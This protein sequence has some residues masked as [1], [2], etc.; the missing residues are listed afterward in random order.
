MNQKE[1]SIFV[2]LSEYFGNKSV[3][4]LTLTDLQSLLSKR[5]VQEKLY[6]H[7]VVTSLLGNILLHFPDVSVIKMEELLNDLLTVSN[8]GNTI[9]IAFNKDT[10][11]KV[12]YY[13]LEND[14]LIYTKQSF[15]KNSCT[16]ETKYYNNRGVK[17]CEYSDLYKLSA[18]PS[19]RTSYY[20][21]K[22]D[23]EGY[24]LEE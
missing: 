18:P 7:P 10:S 17:L 14:C 1:P 6:T 13:K 2:N 20:E 8:K 21:Q 22:I 11:G 4:S 16:T 23:K 19:Y 5:N 3:D 15:V 9:S 12:F 24:S